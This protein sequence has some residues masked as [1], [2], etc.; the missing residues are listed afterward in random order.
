M[1][2]L[3]AA[4]IFNLPTI[5][6]INYKIIELVNLTSFFREHLFLLPFSFPFSRDNRIKTLIIYDGVISGCCLPVFPLALVQARSFLLPP[7]PLLPIFPSSLSARLPIFFPIA[8]PCTASRLFCR[9]FFGL[10][11]RLLKSAS[12]TIYPPPSSTYASAF[13]FSSRLFPASVKAR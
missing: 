11:R 13:S 7:R 3:P 12:T 6:F 9:P 2:G 1:I 5:F 10:G 4:F 8:M